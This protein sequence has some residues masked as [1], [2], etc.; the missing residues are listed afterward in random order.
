MPK[1]PQSSSS[2]LSDDDITALL[3]YQGIDESTLRKFK[4][5]SKRIRQRVRIENSTGASCPNCSKITLESLCKGFTIS[6]SFASLRVLSKV[7]QLCRLVLMSLRNKLPEID[8]KLA[9]DGYGKKSVEVAFD[10]DGGTDIEGTLSQIDTVEQR[11]LSETFWLTVGDIANGIIRV[12]ANINLKS[13]KRHEYRKLLSLDM[14]INRNLS[15]PLDPRPRAEDKFSMMKNWLLEENI[16]PTVLP[17]RR[18]ESLSLSLNYCLPRR[19]IYVPTDFATECGQLRLIAIDDLLKD[20]NQNDSLYC[21]PYLTLSHRWGATHNF[22]TTKANLPSRQCGFALQALPKTY[23]DAAIVTA[24]L[25]YQ[26]IWIDAVCII[27]D[28]AEDWLAESGKMGAIYRLAVCTIA[29]HCSGHDNCGFLEAS[30]SKRGSIKFG[31]YKKTYLRSAADLQLDI[32]K[33]SLSKRGWVLQESLLSTRILHF[34]AGMIYLETQQGV[35]S[36]DGQAPINLAQITANSSTLLTAEIF[37]Y[38]KPLSLHNFSNF[39]T[40]PIS[41]II[42]PDNYQNDPTSPMVWFALLEMYSTCSLSKDYDKLPALL[43]I[44]KIIRRNPDSLYLAGVWDDRLDFG[45]MW[46]N[47]G[48]PLKK[49][50]YDRASSWSWAAYNGPIQFPLIRQKRPFKTFFHFIRSERNHSTSLNEHSSLTLKVDILDLSQA[51][52]SGTL[53]ISLYREE[54]HPTKL[55][56]WEKEDQSLFRDR[57]LN[58]YNV[59]NARRFIWKS[60]KLAPKRGDGSWIVFDTEDFQNAVIK[61]LTFVSLASFQTAEGQD[62]ELRMGIFLIP[63]QVPRSYR[64][65]G[66]GL[67]R[68]TLTKNLQYFG[69][70][71]CRIHQEEITIL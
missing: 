56:A 39:L 16:S 32:T 6:N 19:L 62:V 35:K 59:F 36:E 17:D 71:G 55:K 60:E 61:E 38:H 67:M 40:E 20:Q 4:A 12:R 52:Q 66:A 15:L 58:I 24:R 65:V 26:Y 70:Q 54:L 2:G 1:R 42:R 13:D 69:N 48:H 5:S 31:D 43:G 41:R 28:D 25:G 49:P 18:S 45:L 21:P 8:A 7:C 37:M 3:R 64:R 34:T 53:A 51:L 11:N 57:A 9:E 47:V 68:Q 14:E 23:R 29:I 30:L 46:M 33:S 50:S 63:A 22:V 44:A 10:S 27:Q